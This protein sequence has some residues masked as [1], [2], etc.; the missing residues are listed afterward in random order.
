MQTKKKLC[1]KTDQLYTDI[2][3]IS[4]VRHH[5]FYVLTDHEFFAILKI[6]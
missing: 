6:F 1:K 5:Y 3:R 4:N 2:K